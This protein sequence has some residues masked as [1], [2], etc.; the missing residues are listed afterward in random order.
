MSASTS[1]WARISPSS[2]AVAKVDT[3]TSVAA[4]RQ[5]PKAAASHAGWLAASRPTRA[6]APHPARASSFVQA[7][8]AA[9]SA[10]NDSV[11]PPPIAAGRSPQRRAQSCSS[12]VERHRSAH[13]RPGSSHTSPATLLGSSRNGTETDQVSPKLQK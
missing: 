1:A 7:S 3:G 10:A 5:T 13:G 8:A 9:S 2:R 12:A 4:A 6:P 11:V